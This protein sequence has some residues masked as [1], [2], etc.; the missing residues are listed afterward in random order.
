M[1]DEEARLVIGRV[2]EVIDFDTMR[3]HP[4]LMLD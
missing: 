3:T 4:V 1:S 2:R